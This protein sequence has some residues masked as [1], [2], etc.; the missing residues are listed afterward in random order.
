MM[1][2]SIELVDRCSVRRHSRSKEIE[3]GQ[4]ASIP[5]RVSI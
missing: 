3:R 4:S 2:G 1:A 5:V